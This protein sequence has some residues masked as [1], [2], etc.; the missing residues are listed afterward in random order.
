MA[1]VCWSK[2]RFVESNAATS[3]SEEEWDVEALIITD[4]EE[5]DLITTTSDRIDCEND[6]II[7]SGGLNHMTGDK[8]KLQ[9]LLEYKG[10][11]V[12][13]TTNKSKMPISHI[14]NIV[15]PP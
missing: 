8:E 3:K 12:V 4:E 13:V 6:W 9:N 1:K 7:D 5:I 14:G 11:R 15:V 10:S 2:K